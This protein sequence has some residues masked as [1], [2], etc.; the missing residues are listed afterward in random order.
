MKALLVRLSSVGDVVHTLPVLAALH[1]HGC[2]A[3]WLAESPSRELLEGHPLL[4]RRV[5][6]P[7]ARAFDVGA[8]R[9]AVAELRRERF[10]VALELQGLW[11][12]A[13][14][15]RLS[16]AR[17]VVGYSGRFRREPASAWALGER[18]EQPASA[19]HV[20]DKNLA[21]LRALDI[22]AIGSREFP[23]PPT[24]AARERVARELAALGVGR[25]AL[26][27]PAGGWRNKLWPAERYGALARKLGDRGLRA[28]VTWG[29]GELP[30]AETAAAASG[31]CARVCFETSLLELAELARRAEVVVA[32]DTGPL[33]LACAV[34]AP[35][36]GIYGPT[37]PAR[38]GP[39]SPR[40]EVVR[41]AP[42]CAP[43]HRRDCPVHDGVMAEIPVE[44]L[45]A[46]VERRLARGAP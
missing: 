1:R 6:P 5:E 13:I 41:R 3:T 26:L 28:L 45:A 4:E 25:F 22:E 44:E 40:D 37:D 10:D 19:V 39:F 24:G 9:R 29:P 15:A 46:A 7:R 42:R 16:G 36:V 20:I 43:C 11:K 34:G 12:S 2:A 21:I 14:W 30:L 38:N 27:N 18:L 8:A 32:A 35:A 33:H 23:L 31:G 17:R